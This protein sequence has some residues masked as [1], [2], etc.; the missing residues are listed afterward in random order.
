VSEIEIAIAQPPETQAGMPVLQGP[1]EVFRIVDDQ[2]C[3]KHET[4]PRNRFLLHCD[5]FGPQ[6][7][8]TPKLAMI[9]GR[10]LSIG[11]LSV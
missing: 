3:T 5:R 7:A 1:S 6:W 2:N 10:Q 9:A 4:L 11:A 8:A